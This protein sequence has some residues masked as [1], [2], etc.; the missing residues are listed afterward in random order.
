MQ[1]L[2]AKLGLVTTGDRNGVMKMFLL[3]PAIYTS[4]GVRLSYV[5]GDK[6]L[7]S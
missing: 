5:L 6:E 4:P 7:K 1:N 3:M 2:F